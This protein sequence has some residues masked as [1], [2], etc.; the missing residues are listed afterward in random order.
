MTQTKRFRLVIRL[1]TESF[2]ELQKAHHPTNIQTD[3]QTYSALSGPEAASGSYTGD[4]IPRRKFY[5]A[6]MTRAAA[7]C[8]N[9]LMRSRRTHRK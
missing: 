3:R 7:I 4:L 1:L 9:F 6:T 8:H 2:N 5:D